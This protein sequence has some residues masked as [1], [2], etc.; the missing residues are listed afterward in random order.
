MSAD[1]KYPLLAR[2][3]T[4]DGIECRVVRI[5]DDDHTY[6]LRPAHPEIHGMFLRSSVAEKDLSAWVDPAAALVV[7]SAHGSGAHEPF[8]DAPFGEDG[9]VISFGDA[10]AFVPLSSEAPVETP[11]EVEDAPTYEVEQTSGL[12]VPTAFDYAVLDAE[13]RIVVQ[14]RTRELRDEQQVFERSMQQTTESAWR[15]GERLLD[16]KDRL[17]HGQFA[18]WLSA[19]FPNWG[20][21]SA[22]NFMAIASQF[23]FA[24]VANLNMGLKALYLLAGART[25]EEAREEAIERSDNGERITYSEALEIVNAHK[26]GAAFAA[27]GDTTPAAMLPMPVP[28][29]TEREKALIQIEAY[30]TCYENLAQ[31]VCDGG[32]FKKLLGLVTLL[33]SCAPDVRE[34]MMKANV[35]DQSLIRQINDAVSQQREAAEEIL[36]TG[37]LQ[38]TDWSVLL[39]QATAQDF[40][41]LMDE[42]YKEH[43]AQ[44]IAAK[45]GEPVSVVLYYDDADGSLNAIAQ[46]FSRQG[47][48]ALFEAIKKK[49]SL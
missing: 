4:G 42:R 47:L 23:K 9:S 19:E 16:V 30:G 39:S 29:P 11:P 1:S 15:M 38:G 35:R 40:R 26:N 20:H 28:A 37:V 12:E 6:S 13:S 8:P 46:V 7:E 3:T 45:R 14:Q 25:P 33:D 49:L 10:A 36:V 31:E 18:K 32:D 24:T 41:K 48:V 2:V 43:V 27:V 22:D 34:A 5:N 17:D 44:S 21:R